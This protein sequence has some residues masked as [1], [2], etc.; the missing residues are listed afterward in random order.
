MRSC[1]LLLL[2]LLTVSCSS[3]PPLR[4]ENAC[5]LF[6]DKPSWY[7][8]MREAGKKWKVPMEMIMAF[9][10]QESHFQSTAR[11]KKS[12]FLGFI[13]RGYTSSAR[14][15]S[16]A[17]DGTWKRYQKETG[18]H[19]AQRDNIEDSADFVGWYLTDAKKKIRV[20][21]N[22]TYHLYLVYH[23]G[24]DGY[25]SKTYLQKLWLLQVAKNV[26]VKEKQY[27][28]QIRSCMGRRFASVTGEPQ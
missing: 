4:V 25:K 27:Q 26:A 6:S 14:G 7:V 3:R 15:Y 17:L 13:P 9:V 19:G 12:Y 16:Q 1:W 18:K 20:R 24:V 22:D 21:A 2:S 11:P 28:R 5:E 10:H 8:S 23:E